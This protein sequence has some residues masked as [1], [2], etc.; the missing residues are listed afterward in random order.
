M[1][2]VSDGSETVDS[3]DTLVRPRG[4]IDRTS[5]AA[6]IT[7]ITDET[8]RDAPPIETVFPRIKAIIESSPLVIAHNASFDR[9]VVDIEAERL[10]QKVA[11]PRVLCTV[12][13]TAHLK[14]YRL[15]LSDL[16][17]EFFGERF[18]G[19]HRARVDV[20]ALARIV[21]EMIRRDLL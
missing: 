3:L 5:K 6:E 8:L 18:A 15:S 7:G 1:E 19:A 21:V 16:Y 17:F 12:E 20:D 9:E 13:Q 10:N 4:S 14:G 2:L 11:W